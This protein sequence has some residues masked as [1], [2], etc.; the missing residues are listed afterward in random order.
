MNRHMLTAWIC[1]HLME[2]MS[3]VSRQSAMEETIH[4]RLC[5]HAHKDCGTL[6]TQVFHNITCNFKL[7]VLSNWSGP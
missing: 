1:V 4:A 3:N 5:R 6:S 2:G 7:K